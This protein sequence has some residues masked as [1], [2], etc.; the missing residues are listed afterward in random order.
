MK[1]AAVLNNHLTNMNGALFWKCFQT[2]LTSSGNTVDFLR[3]WS[4]FTMNH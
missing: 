1:A 2:E 3:T 4:A